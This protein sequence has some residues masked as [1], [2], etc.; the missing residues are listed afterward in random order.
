MARSR[1]LV[2]A[3]KSSADAVG[4]SIEA[5]D[6]Y[7]LVKTPFK[8]VEIFLNRVQQQL[9]NNSSSISNQATFS[10][11]LERRKLLQSEV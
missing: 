2:P 11:F 9:L 6:R 7:G 10:A 3:K 5:E 4:K 8:R 1:G